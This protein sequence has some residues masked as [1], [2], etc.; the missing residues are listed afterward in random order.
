V[1]EEE[2]GVSWSDGGVVNVGKIIKPEMVYRTPT[3][4][5]GLAWDETREAGAPY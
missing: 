3:D 2:A 5:M 1:K 4:P